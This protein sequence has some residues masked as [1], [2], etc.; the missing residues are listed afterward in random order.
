MFF[1]QGY[2]DVDIFD[3]GYEHV[4]IEDSTDAGAETSAY[5]NTS[6]ESSE[7]CLVT[8]GS[9]STSNEKL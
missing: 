2:E 9:A 3:D 5:V 8:A 4:V 7:N 1:L 6:I